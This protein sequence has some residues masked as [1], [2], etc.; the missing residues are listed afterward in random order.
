MPFNPLVAPHRPVKINM[1]F[2]YPTFQETH[3]RHENPVK[4][5][6]LK[7]GLSLTKIATEI[8]VSVGMSL[9]RLR[10]HWLNRNFRRLSR[11]D[12]L[13]WMVQCTK[14]TSIRFHSAIFYCSFPCFSHV[15]VMSLFF[16][17]SYDSH[18]TFRKLYLVL[19]WRRLNTIRS[20]TS[21]YC[22]N[23]KFWTSYSTMLNISYL[24]I[25]V[26]HAK[27]IGHSADAKSKF[28]FQGNNTSQV[29]EY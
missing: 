17:R 3:L 15:A 19:I 18:S 14:T 27:L 25:Q 11:G 7:V 22:P 26:T 9:K 24:D 13:N 4:I 10:R 28:L 23:A 16:A 21:K 20:D 5:S 12:G 2:P 29:R 1:L 8:S 6:N